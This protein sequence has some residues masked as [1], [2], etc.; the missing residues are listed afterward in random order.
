MYKLILIYLVTI[1]LVLVLN[2]DLYFFICLLLLSFIIDVFYSFYKG[3]LKPMSFI[4]MSLVY[5]LYFSVILLTSVYTRSF[6]KE[7]S[8]K[9]FS[10]SFY[11]IE[12]KVVE[13]KQKNNTHTLVLKTESITDLET[14][15][16][17]NI[18]PTLLNISVSPNSKIDLYN[19]LE[20]VGQIKFTN[21]YVY[22]EKRSMFYN[23][24]LENIFNNTNYE[25]TQIR[26]ISVTSTNKNF[27][28]TVSSNFYK[29]SE[30][31]KNKIF[32]NMPEPFASVAQGISVGDQANLNKEIKDIFRTSGLIHILVLSGANVSFIISLLWYF[33]RKS[34][35]KFKTFF[36]IFISWIFIAA[37]GFT[38]PS[39]RAGV[40]STGNIMSEYFGKN[41]TNF[42]SLL[43]S[44]F[45]LTI[46]NPRTLV[47]S[48][49]LHLSYLA[50]F[51]LFLIAPKFEN[52]FLKKYLFLKKHKFVNFILSNTLAFSLTTSPYILV[53]TGQTNLFGTILT[54]LVEPIVSV[55]IVLSFLIIIFSSINFWVINIFA[56][57]FGILNTFFVKII[58]LIANFG[59]NNLPILKLD[60]SPNFLLIYLF[61]L[62]LVFSRKELQ[63]EFFQND[64]ITKS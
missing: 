6:E 8:Y 21:Y 47:F 33:L 51:G 22:N 43:L 57:F 61:I 4:K 39:I 12:G 1:P 15:T 10:D 64:I 50:V 52:F 53:L 2:A 49:S 29:I 44:L 32:L 48:P 7:V 23:Y 63:S 38:A 17:E 55:V 58:L 24:E 40:M 13:V 5:S 19:N 30:S 27:W 28:E 16:L 11:R 35:T 46:L 3:H 9:D 54:F 31:L 42:R 20:I 14:N 41:F 59:A 62:L 25:V 37:T 45:V 56:T 36:G 34:K 26:N 60:I 18:P